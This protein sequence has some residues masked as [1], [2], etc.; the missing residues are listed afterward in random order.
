MREIR[1]LAWT[2]MNRLDEGVRLRQEQGFEAARE[3]VSGLGKEEM[4]A[5]R[6]AVVRATF[7]EEALLQ[8][9]ERQ[10]ERS[11]WIAVATGLVSALAA[12]FA[13]A[14]LLLLLRRYCSTG[15]R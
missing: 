15:R 13:L 6:D 12:L 10:S 14:A 5:L 4:D 9:R 11:Y 7:E 8:E 1:K 3:A 2:R